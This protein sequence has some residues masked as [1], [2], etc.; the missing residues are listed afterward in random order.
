ML[1]LETS[2]ADRNFASL[3]T[4][5]RCS[6]DADGI[7]DGTALFALESSCVGLAEGCVG[8]KAAGAPITLWSTEARSIAH[9]TPWLGGDSAATREPGV[10]RPS[11]VRQSQAD[12]G[13]G[14][15]TTARR[16]R[17]GHSANWRDWHTRCALRR[18]RRERQSERPRLPRKAK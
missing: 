18:P 5:G 2:A 1:H 12:E 15:T 14:R 7:S 9:R 4:H 16:R 3:S 6:G 11:I 13:L 8:L 17:T 10:N